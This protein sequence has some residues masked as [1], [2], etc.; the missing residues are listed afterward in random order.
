MRKPLVVSPE[1]LR[2]LTELPRPSRDLCQDAIF[3]VVEAFGRPHT[4]LGLGIRKLKPSL[5]E[6]RAGLNLRILFRDRPDSLCI[7]FIGTHDE[8]QKELRSGKHD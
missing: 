8:V 7:T 3:A 4:H 2:R 1:A 5:F 6:C